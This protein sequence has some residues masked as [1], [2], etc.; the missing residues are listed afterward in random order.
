MNKNSKL[1]NFV[2][3]K[4]FLNGFKIT[5]IN[6]DKTTNKKTGITKNIIPKIIHKKGLNKYL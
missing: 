1:R 4:I 6:P 5:K 2:T 3:L